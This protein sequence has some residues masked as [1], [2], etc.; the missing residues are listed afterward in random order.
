MPRFDIYLKVETE[1]KGEDK[2]EKLA[3]ELCRQLQKFYGVRAAEL[4]NY[5]LQE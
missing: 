5:V 2:P 4:V 1:L 3:A